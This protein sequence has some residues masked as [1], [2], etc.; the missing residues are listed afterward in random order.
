[1]KNQRITVLVWAAG[2][3]LALVATGAVAAAPAPAVPDAAVP[4]GA[5]STPAPVYLNEVMPR[6]GAGQHQWVE[7]HRERVQ[8]T[9]FLPLVLRSG[10]GALLAASATAALPQAAAD[11]DISGWQVSNQSGGIYTIPAALPPVPSNAYILIYFDGLGPAADDT[12]FADGRAVLHTPAGLADIFDTSVDQVALYTSATHNAQTIRDFVAYG[13]APGAAANDAIAAGLWQAGWWVELH[14][15]TGAADANAAVPTKQSIGLYPGHANQSPDDWA[16]YQEADLTPGAANP[17]PTAAWST[18]TTGATMASDGFALGWPF[19]PGAT[20]QL[21]MD[22][23]PQFGSPAVNL[24]LA[25][26]FYAPTTPPAAGSYWWR[27][28]AIMGPDQMAAWSTPLQVTIIPVTTSYAAQDAASVQSVESVNVVNVTWL[29]QRKDTRLLCLDGD[30]E[31]NPATNTSEEAWDAIHPDA[32]YTHGR[33]NCVRASIAM[34]VTHYGGNLSQDRLGYRLFEN[35]GNPIENIGELNNPLRDLGHDRTT[36][37]CGNTG[38]NGGQLLAWA[39]GINVADYTY[40]HINLTAKPSFAQIRTWIDAGRPIMR[41]FSGHQT[42][43]GGYRTLGDGTQ[44]IRLFDPWSAVTWEN[45]NGIT[46]TCWYVPPAAAPNVRSDEASISTDS[47]GDGIMDWDE[48]N[49]FP[50]SSVLQDTDGDWVKDK[51]DLREYV[52]DSAGTYSLRGAD[53][54]GDGTRKEADPDNDNDG[55]VDGCEDNNYNGK[56]EAGLGESNNFNAASHRACTPIFKILQPTQSNPVN[57]GAFNGPDKILVQVQTAVPPAA[58]PLVYTAGDFTV[59]IGGLDSPVVAAYPVADT[60]FLVVT[61]AAQPAA[62]TYDLEVTLLGTYTDSETR[63]VF[64]LPRLRADQMLVIDRSG[65]MITDNKM[66]AAKNAARA[67]IDHTNV[68]DMIGVVSFE[69]TAAV[70]YVLTTVT[71]NPEWNAAKAAVN[72]LVT[73]N[74]TALGPGARLG[75]DQIVASGQANHDWSMALMT[76]G[77]ENITPYWADPTVG[78]VIIPS[79]VVVHTV[80][81][82]SDADTTLLASIA[83]A[84]GGT[85]YEAGTDLLPLAAAQSAATPV[86]SKASGPLAPPMPELPT[87]LPNRLANVYKAIGEEIGHQ[88]R[89]FQATGQFC[90]KPVVYEV[91]LEK[92]LPE[93]IFTVNW[94]DP[95]N[96]ITLILTDPSGTVIGHKPPAVREIRD[97]THHQFRVR[98]PEGGVWKVELRGCGAY[99]LIVSA[100]SPTTMHL[101]FGL[102]AEQRTVGVPL[103]IIVVLADEKPIPN[104]EVWVQIQGPNSDLKT[105]LQLFDDGGHEDG[106]ADDGVYGNRYTPIKAGQHAVNAAGWGFNNAGDEFIRYRIGAFT[107]RPRVAYIW[108]DDLKTGNAYRNLLVAHG[109]IV[110]FVHMGEVAG[111]NWNPYNL[112]VVGPETGNGANWGTVAAVAALEKSSK[113]IVGLGEGGY[114]F[115]GKVKPAIGYPNGWHGT[116]NRTYVMDTLHEV[117]HHPYDI[118]FGRERIVTVYNKTAHVGIQVPTRPPT[119]MTLIGREPADQTHYNLIQQTARY[120]LWGFQNGP[121]AMTTEGRQLFINVARHLAGM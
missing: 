105:F 37:V 19:V 62:D 64:Y 65:S 53:F 13:G 82:G 109:Y 28:R 57:A 8:Y 7:L 77:M 111:K 6:P 99:L 106:K 58:T 89:L 9:L 78:G 119:D 36:L 73:G 27:V 50:T 76:D 22:D 32:I 18:V 75:Y 114:A 23:D 104:A 43:I 88:Q 80:A 74:M 56:Y 12:D 60:H 113:P 86:W 67:F 70:N 120:L 69:T 61:P 121:A 30:N 16:F 118:A 102:P 103:P 5:L 44:Q 26:P 98:N 51:Q 34:I 97:D 24:T 107:A 66:D 93:A 71:G 41:F 11:P 47:D 59:R 101:G 45:Y 110:D 117:W 68:D 14:L 55:S 17:V 94:D 52:F 79:R 72:A 63:A 91:L 116:E 29:R 39:L 40:G 81:L 112:I 46:L 108:Q 33:N 92:G 20:Y 87:T 1:M 84:T 35:W 90:E 38:S 83:G 3:I 4:P 10:T 85:P 21:Q 31:G 100:W 25:Q 42:V 49:R 2:L 15:G 96:S 48:Q 115:F 95:K 54:D